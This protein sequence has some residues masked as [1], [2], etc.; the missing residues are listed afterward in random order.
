MVLLLLR[1]IVTKELIK[2][3]QNE[4]K[5]LNRTLANFMKFALPSKLEKQPLD[6]VKL[7]QETLE[8]FDAEF[9]RRGINVKLDLP[10]KCPIKADPTSLKQLLMNLILNAISAMEK[11]IEKRL[12]IN[13]FP[14]GKFWHLTL[15]DTGHGFGDIDPEK[16]FEVFY[17]TKPNG[18]GFGLPIARQIATAHRGDLRAENVSPQGGARCVSGRASRPSGGIRRRIEPT[19]VLVSPP[20]TGGR[21]VTRW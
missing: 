4:I 7:L 19:M 5:Q 2:N 15:T 17:T 16:C 20:C 13:L 1:S 8:F 11:S 14:D 21:P 10:P 9:K 3:L 18:S 6:L 12:T